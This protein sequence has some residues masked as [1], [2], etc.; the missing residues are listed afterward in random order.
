MTTNAMDTNAMGTDALAA[1]L[2]QVLRQVPAVKSL[3]TP[4]FGATVNRIASAVAVVE[5]PEAT[6][7]VTAEAAGRVRVA[8]HL[9]VGDELPAP[10][11][12]R[13]ASDAITEYLATRPEPVV[14]D[15]IVIQI[16]R[17]G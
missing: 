16:R 5:S 4:G 6:V 8:C 13:A 10:E 9:H 12:V 3:F 17:V 1:E 15:S 14:V 11:T 2:A 7:A